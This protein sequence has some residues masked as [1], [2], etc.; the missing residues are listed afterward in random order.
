MMTSASWQS[1]FQLSLVV[2]LEQHV[3]TQVEGQPCETM[4]LPVGEE[5]GDEQHGVRAPGPGL[6]DLVLVHYEV[7]AQHRQP[8]GS[9][10]LRRSS[11]PPW[12]NSSS[13]STDTARAPEAS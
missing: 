13:V 12:K 2:D 1:S 11:G 10:R 3:K 8:G 9:Y 6:M 5:G 4:Q 7:L